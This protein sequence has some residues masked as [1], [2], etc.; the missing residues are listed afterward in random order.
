MLLNILLYVFIGAAWLSLV[1]TILS[2]FFANVYDA[3][4]ITRVKRQ[5]Q[6]PYGKWRTYRPPVDIIMAAYN[7]EAVIERS[8]RSILKS[9]Y[10]NYRLIVVDDGS[11]DKTSLVVQRLMAEFPTK[12]IKLITK[13]KNSGK[14]AAIATGLRRYARGELLMT[15][16]ADC[17]IERG[18]ITNAVRYFIDPQLAALAANVRILPSDTLL[19]LLQRYEYLVGF[20]SKKFNAA[21]NCEYIVG[22]AG[23][24]YR[25]RIFSKV[26]KNL[27][28]MQTEDIAISLAIAKLGNKAHRIGYSSDVLLYT[29]HA[30]TYKGLFRQR[31]RWKVGALQAIYLNRSVIFSPRGKYSKSLS[32]LRLPMAIW[33]E[34]LLMWEPIFFGMFLYL[35]I[36]NHNAAFYFGACV[37]MTIILLINVWCDEHYRPKDKL[38]LSVMAPAIYPLFFIMSSVQIAAIFKCLLKPSIITG[39][40]KVGGSWVS[41]LR[42]GL[43]AKV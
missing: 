27:T 42:L 32:W 16:D 29:E 5:R 19:G 18:T 28:D 12:N 34:F 7:E 31:F 9:T 30:P 11:K 41:P 15:I 13:R 6:Q 33:S 24:M 39:K 38:A 17:Q 40:T 1:Y 20:R 37:T 21:A 26:S 8:I 3:K 10:R 36:I 23:A 43:K 35:S 22:G 4:A 14:G 2:M 25:R